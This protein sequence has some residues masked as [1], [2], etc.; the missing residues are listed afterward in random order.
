MAEKDIVYYYSRE[1]RLTRASPEVQAL[2]DG[3][4]IR[5]SLS[6]T[7]FATKAHRLVFFSFVVIIAVSSLAS[8]FSKTDSGAKGVKLGEN[9]L[10]LTL[11]PV[12]GALILGIIK[13]T[14]QSGE[15]YAGAVDIAVSPVQ[16]RKTGE[17]AEAPLVFS[18]RISFT[19]VETEVFQAAVPFD[20]TDFLILLSAGDEQKAVRLKAGK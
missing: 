6:K 11:R 13:N 16:Q 18:H 8:R 12:E 20:G 5:S 3:I 10:V 7:F 2:N 4:P 17:T 19:P 15:F 14:P 9:T 1:R